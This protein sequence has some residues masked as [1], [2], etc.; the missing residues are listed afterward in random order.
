MPGLKDWFFKSRLMR[1]KYIPIWGSLAAGG[2]FAG[3]M[4]GLNG[5]VPGSIALGFIIAGV[6]YLFIFSLDWFDMDGF[7]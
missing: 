6:L 3:F 5:S 1:K 4:F 7:M 2:A